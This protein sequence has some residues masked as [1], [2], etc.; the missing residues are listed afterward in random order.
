MKKLLVNFDRIVNKEIDEK[1]QSIEAKCIISDDFRYVEK[2]QD[3]YDKI[4]ILMD[5]RNLDFSALVTLLS[6]DPEFNKKFHI[7]IDAS[8][9]DE[10]VEDAVEGLVTAIFDFVE[11][12]IIDDL[13]DLQTYIF[14][15]I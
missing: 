7:I 1:I 10:D 11:G 15:Y 3:N 13:E 2:I 4:V 5:D 12:V 14:N 8:Q 6:R 9:F